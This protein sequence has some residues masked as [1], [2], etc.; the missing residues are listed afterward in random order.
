MASV[1][2]LAAMT[3][4]QTVEWPTPEWLF[5]QLDRE[6]HFTVDVAANP[7][8]AKVPTKFYTVDDDG[9][10]QSWD[11]ETVW[12]NPPYGDQLKHWVYKAA[13][14]D[15]LTVMLVPA[16]VDTIWFH[17]VVLNR[18]EIRF[19]KG[20]LKFGDATDSAPFPCMLLIFRNALSASTTPE[21]S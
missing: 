15:A 13:T 17:N 8:N 19:I 6:F 18:A 7:S 3:S 9:L 21:E 4:S 1:G 16:R 2:A 14:S 20:R 5:A 10:S 11:G 12:C